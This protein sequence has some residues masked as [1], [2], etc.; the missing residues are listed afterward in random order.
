MYYG[1]RQRRSNPYQ[2]EVLPIITGVVALLLA[3]SSFGPWAHDFFGDKQGTDMLWGWLA[4]IA[5]VVVLGAMVHRLTNPG[6]SLGPRLALIAS[7]LT[8]LIAI[9]Y[10][11]Y[12][13]VETANNAV[14]DEELGITFLPV[15]PEWGLYLAD[16]ASIAL[17]VLSFA[18]LLSRS[19][20][21]RQHVSQSEFGAVAACPGC[22]R[23]LRAAYR[24]CPYCRTQISFPAA[25]SRARAGARY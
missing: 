9:G 7:A 19:G 22:R 24:F 16:F 25:R 3:L 17:V 11:A 21:Q 2:V 23:E 14:S 13:L 6:D 1:A 8:A 5:A 18:M 12:V 20:G 10:T 4:L 15:S